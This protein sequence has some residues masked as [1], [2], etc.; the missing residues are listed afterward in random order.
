MSESIG[1]NA[2]AYINHGCSDSPNDP[3]RLAKA[4][5]LANIIIDPETGF[6]PYWVSAVKRLLEALMI[7]VATSPVAATIQTN[8][9]TTVPVRNRSLEEVHRL[10]TQEHLALNTTLAVMAQSPEDWVRTSAE[11]LLQMEGGR[12]LER[13]CIISTLTRQIVSWDCG[14]RFRT[15]ATTFCCRRRSSSSD[16]DQGRNLCSSSR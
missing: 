1:W 5:N 3:S 14:N 9:R 12:R 2:I 11:W 6:D 10:L 16:G 7:F 15:F 4:R 8:D 13:A